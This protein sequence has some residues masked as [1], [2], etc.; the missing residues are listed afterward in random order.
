VAKKKK[1]ETPEEQPP[2][3]V[4]PE[5]GIY[6]GERIKAAREKKGL[7]LREI[8]DRTKIN[9]MTLQA[10]EE[11]RYESM[12]NA[13][14]Y[15]RGFVRCLAEEIGLDKDAVSQSYVPRWERWFAGNVRPA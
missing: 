15:V 10:L 2:A 13:R 9:L 1:E 11:E 12:P 14:V 8:A 5:D 3:P 6:T 4:A 7:T